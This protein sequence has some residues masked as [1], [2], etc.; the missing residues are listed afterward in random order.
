MSSQGSPDPDGS[1][2][3]PSLGTLEKASVFA[4][5]ILLLTTLVLHWRSRRDA[6]SPTQ[7]P[8]VSDPDQTVTAYCGE[9]TQ[10]EGRGR[11]VVQL[12]PLH[13]D[14]EQQAFDAQVLR[15]RL[16]LGPGAPWRLR[17]S[18]ERA[19]EASSAGSPEPALSLGELSVRD[20][21]G[22][23]LGVVLPAG[24]A[25][26]LDPLVAL[27]AAPGGA[28]Q[29]GQGIDLVL[30]GRAPSGEAWLDGVRPGEASAPIA[31]ALRERELRRSELGG[32][33][34]RLDRP[35][36][37]SPAASGKNPSGDPSE[38][39]AARSASADEDPRRE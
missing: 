2:R 35:Q 3:R 6:A 37:P 34:A 15:R 23:A 16:S 1:A 33:L 13:I 38:D 29:A 17:L 10:P 24:S 12:A 14:P 28:L 26:P 18:W 9:W 39:P 8:E 27:F 21:T 22:R 11:L 19:S 31:V 7:A 30:W 25:L 32:P 20:A 4:L 36:S 5:T